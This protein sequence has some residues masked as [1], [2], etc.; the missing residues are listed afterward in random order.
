MECNFVVRCSPAMTELIRF[1]REGVTAAWAA[2]GLDRA[3][4]AATVRA[5]G[6]ANVCSLFSALQPGRDHLRTAIY[7]LSCRP[8]SC[9]G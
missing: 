8:R 5:A 7:T 4:L 9:S 6:M 2:R 3:A 1:L